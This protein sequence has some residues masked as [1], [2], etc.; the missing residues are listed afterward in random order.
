MHTFEYT[1][2][3]ALGIHVRPA[4]LLVQQAQK[5]RSSVTLAV[6][7]GGDVETANLKR[8][9][10]L[11]QLNIRAGETVFITVDGPDEAETAPALEAF[12]R[13]HL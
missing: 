7:R 5:A 12:L 1:I 9:F 6:R 3:D 2:R 10:T 11:M 13:A 4:G 8:L